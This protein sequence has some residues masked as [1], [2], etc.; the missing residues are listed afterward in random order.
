MNSGKI[1]IS[2]CA[3]TADDLFRKISRAEPL[4]DIVE[5]RFDCLGHGEVDAALVGL[6]E[7]SKPY[8]LTFRPSE[9]GGKRVLPPAT[10]IMFW[11]RATKLL[12]GRDFFVDQESDLEFSF[13][14]DSSR[15]IRSHH[16]FGDSPG[17]LRA[18]YF[19]LTEIADETVKIAI[20]CPDITD[21]IKV[22]KLLETA[23]N[24]EGRIVPI[25]MGEAGKWTRVLG[26]AYGAFMTYAALDENEATAPGQISAVDMSSVFRVKS[27]SKETLVHG[28]IAGDTSYSV[29]PWMH[30]SAFDAAG[31]DRVFVPLQVRELSAFIRR[32][33][34][35]ET[36]EID[37]NFAGF[38]VTNPHKQAII[39][40]LD[41]IDETARIIG[42]VN[43]VAVENGKLLGYNT[44]APGFIS[45]LRKAFGDLRSA[46]VF[47]AGA[48][49]AARA[50][51]YALKQE[52]SEVTVLARNPE[53]ARS[54]AQEFNVAYGELQSE[55]EFKTDILVNTTPLGTKGKLENDT[56]ATAKQLSSVKLVYD[57]VYNPPVTRLLREA[58]GAGVA[59]IGGLE[60]LVA[61]GSRQ[62]ELWTSESPPV[63][64]MSAAVKKRLG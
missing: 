27:L 48:G 24:N 5:V 44:D 61:Q 10:R 41:A 19:E 8:L 34:R 52:G 9:Q 56:I 55:E 37:V 33:V 58:K 22:W 7:I 31:M 17:D 21:T 2:V 26:P 50:C 62:F 28:V 51:V 43:T 40:H 45:P 18:V 42:A 35:P 29:S 13:G 59:A 1:C 64:V 46:R 57:L 60:M 54:L 47:V 49:G 15:V 39:G 36:R 20:T 32:M 11:R 25:A 23:E 63:E 4:A 6:P 38:S 30:N 53:K 14:F 3:G 16:F 12:A